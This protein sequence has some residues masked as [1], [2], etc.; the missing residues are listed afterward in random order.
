MLIQL[1]E[2]FEQ[3]TLKRRD[4]LS[5]AEKRILQKEENLDKRVDLLEKKEKDIEERVGS[6]HQNEEGL[7]KERQQLVHL[8]EEEKIRLQKLS[9]MTTE[10]AKKLLLSRVDEELI[11]EKA[12]RIREMESD[13]KETADK[14]AREILSGAIHRC[15]SEH[16]G[17]TTISVVHL[18]SDEMKGRIIGRE[19]R[20]IRAFEMA[21]GVDIIIDDTPEAVTISGFDMMRREIAK[22]ALD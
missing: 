22:I 13:L 12:S 1:R 16:A 20:N 8:V 7:Q 21:T 9:S 3:E 18:P 10:E 17:D 5:S 19:G 14:K 2:S 4:E 6:L 15:A 11:A